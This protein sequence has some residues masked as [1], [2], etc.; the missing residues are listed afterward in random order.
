MDVT[1]MRNYDGEPLGETKISDEEFAQYMQAAQQPEGLI[2]LGNLRAILG[3]TG[4]DQDLE[5]LSVYL[6]ES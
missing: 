5:N 2:G 3:E 4:V 6:I 1:I